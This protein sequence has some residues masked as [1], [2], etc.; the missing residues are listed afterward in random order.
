MREERR[1]RKEQDPRG[2][3]IEYIYM[4]TIFNIYISILNIQYIHKYIGNN[5]F[6]PPG[7]GWCIYQAN[8]F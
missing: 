8:M 2:N 5:S 3:Y 1:D 6:V 7:G 4:Y